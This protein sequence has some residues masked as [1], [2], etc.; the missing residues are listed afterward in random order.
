MLNN[1]WMISSL[2]CWHC[3][4]NEKSFD[5]FLNKENPSVIIFDRFLMEEQFGWKVDSNVFKILDTQ[6]LHFLRK[7]R[8]EYT[9]QHNT[10]APEVTLIVFFTFFTI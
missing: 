7:A 8:M 4:P 3:P 10:I 9:K 5:E 6:D 1:N 2:L